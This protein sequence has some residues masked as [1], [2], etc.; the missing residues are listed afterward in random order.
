M[1]LQFIATHHDQLSAFRGESAKAGVADKK[2]STH[3]TQPTAPHLTIHSQQQLACQA[4]RDPEWSSGKWSFSELHRQLPDRANKNLAN[5]N[6]SLTQ[7]G[8]NCGGGAVRSGALLIE[9]K[10]KAKIMFYFPLYPL[11]TRPT[12]PFPL[13]F[14][15]PFSLQAIQTAHPGF[16]WQPLQPSKMAAAPGSWLLLLPSLSIR[17]VW[18]LTPTPTTMPTFL[19]CRTALMRNDRQ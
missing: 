13:P 10:S 19:S 18:P 8:L 17:S 14:P 6:S 11:A 2:L 9:N 15:F 12:F 7:K 16:S 3:P 5:C 4:H 1:A